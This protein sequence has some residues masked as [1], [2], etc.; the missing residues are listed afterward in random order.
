MTIVGGAKGFADR[1]VVVNNE[2]AI[3]GQGS[4]PEPAAHAPI[5]NV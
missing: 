2:V 1:I 4:D 3:V 5:H